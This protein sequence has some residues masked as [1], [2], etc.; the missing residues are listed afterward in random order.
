MQNLGGTDI[1]ML[2]LWGIVSLLQVFWHKRVRKLVS[3]VR[4]LAHP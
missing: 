1:M 4:K 3:R 2:E